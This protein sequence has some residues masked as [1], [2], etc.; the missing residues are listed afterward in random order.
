MIRMFSPTLV[1]TAACAAG[2]PS[3]AS[4]RDAFLA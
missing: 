1:V 4:S 2:Y 3:P